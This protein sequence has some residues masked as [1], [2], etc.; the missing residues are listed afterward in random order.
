[1]KSS[2]KKIALIV[3]VLVIALAV[4]IILNQENINQAVTKYENMKIE[5][6]YEDSIVKSFDF[7]DIQELDIHTFDAFLNE[8]GKEPQKNEYTG[9]LV[10][11]LLINSN[12][13]I[14]NIEAIL[15]TAVDGYTVAVEKEKVIE[16]DNVYL[17]F[18]QNDKFLKSKEDGGEGPYQ[19]VIAKDQFSQYW[20]K[21]VI[22][23]E[24][25]E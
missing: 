10:K 18:K 8:S 13:D 11:D 1:M 24:V 15:V 3:L 5:I 21:Y 25:V 20:C 7:D 22:K 4:L 17:A 16:E 6:I 19:M 23:I 2:S 14:T 9:V 12:I